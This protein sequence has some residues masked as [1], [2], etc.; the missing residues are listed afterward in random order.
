MTDK[1]IGQRMTSQRKVIL[2][3]IR[4]SEGHLQADEI[5]QL[6]K[7]KDDRISLSTVYRN[8]NL[9]KESGLVVERHL[10]EEHHHYELN[11]GPD[12]QHLICTDCGVVFEFK[13]KFIEKLLVEAENA[14]K[15]KITHIEIDMIGLCPQCQNEKPIDN[16]ISI[17]QM[18]AGQSGRIVEI[19]RGREMKRVEAMGLRMGKNVIKVSG[20]FGH[21]PVTVQAGRTQL[22]LGHGMAKKILVEVKGE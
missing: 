18:A 1:P 12:H 11:I 7:V 6:A 20:M 16:Q 19:G 9:L 17:A 22:A 5:L 14:S 8:L 13:S 3:I 21:G 10:G 15:F 2:D 4:S